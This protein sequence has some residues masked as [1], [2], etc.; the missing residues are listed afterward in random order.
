M[1]RTMFKSK[2][3][4]ATV[5][6]ADLHYVGSV[7]IDADLMEA[8]DLLP[9]ELV[10]IVDITNGARLETYVIEGRRGSGTIGINGAAAHLVNPGDLVILISYAQVDDAEA[11]ALV[12]RVVHVGADN[13][14]VELGTDAGAPVPGSRTERSP[15]AVG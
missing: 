6:H 11:R 15:G 12:P 13:R 10:H 5:T 9:G 2:I 7:T 1:M 3:H 14:I 4:R 8:A